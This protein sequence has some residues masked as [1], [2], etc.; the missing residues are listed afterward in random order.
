M[1]ALVYTQ[2][3][4]VQL[5]ER[6]LP[7]AAAGEVVL[8]IEAVGICGSDMHAWHGHDPRRKPGLVLGHEFVGRVEHSA[9]PG[10]EVGTRF[11]GNPLITCGVCAYCVQGRNNLCSNR[12][13]VGMSRPGA[14]AQF[15]SI[16]AASLVAM[17][18]TLPARVAALTEPAATAWHAINLTMRALVRPIH[19]CRVLVIG[20]G[21]IGILTALLLRHLGCRG[22]DQLMLTELN[23]LRR[24]AVAQHAGC[25]TL[26]PR[27]AAPEENGFDVVIDAVG[28]KATR[29]QAFSAVKPGGVIMHVGLQD[30][31][32]EIDMRKLTL[33]E[34]TLLGTYTYTT[35]DL[36]ATVAA[37]AQGVFGDLAWVQE[38]PLAEG[39]QAFLDLDQGLLA[40][41]KVLLVP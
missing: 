20:G 9:A 26:D 21:A 25:S 41:A 28:A 27:Q 32:S 30:W 24:E 37:L 33:A 10:F 11:T 17:P 16:P 12:S 34:I 5:Q 40:T 36:R 3:H 39:Q 22:E 2:P 8:R 29:V 1:K 6:P 35:A 38:R 31:A 7:E 15:M 4:E 14:F 13:M 19:E 23:P 18:Q